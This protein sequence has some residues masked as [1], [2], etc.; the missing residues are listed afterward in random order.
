MTAATL[1]KWALAIGLGCYASISLSLYVLQ[2]RLIYPAPP[3]RSWTPPRAQV[4]SYGTKDG[5][6]LRGGYAPAKNDRQTLLFFHGNGSDWQSTFQILEPLRN[7]G[8]GLMAA[9]YRGYNGNPGVVSEAGLYEDGSAAREF[10]H[11]RAVTDDK[12]VIVG[13]SLGSG[14]ATELARKYE[15]AALILISPFDSMTQT[16]KNKL[17]WLPIDLLLKTK[18][19]NRARIAVVKAPT[20]IVHGARDELIYLDQAHALAESANNVEFV[21]VKDRGHDLIVDE[22]LPSLIDRFLRQKAR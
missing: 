21:T 9:E 3:A 18:M 17:P 8:Y 10:L 19:D 13:N 14:V 2:D 6:T 5:L 12:I 15:V 7:Y 1:V 20:L 4:V 16:V 22:R 11:S